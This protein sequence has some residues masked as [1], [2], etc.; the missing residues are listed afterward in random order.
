MIGGVL[1]YI[2]LTLVLRLGFNAND[3]KLFSALVVAVFMGVPY[4]KAQIRAKA[5]NT[6]PGLG[7]EEA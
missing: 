2:V 4:W 7:K 6:N 5:A 3:L 1:Y